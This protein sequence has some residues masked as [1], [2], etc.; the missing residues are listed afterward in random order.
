MSQSYNFKKRRTI[1]NFWRKITFV[2]GNDDCR[3]PLESFMLNER[4][5]YAC[6]AHNF[7]IPVYEIENAVNRMSDEIVAEAEDG[8]AVDLTNYKWK[9]RDKSTN[10][11]YEFK[12]LVHS[13]SKILVSVAEVKSYA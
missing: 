9:Q 8:C 3:E 5:Y 10:R 2:C 4:A 12:V 1:T 6:Q 13:N 11:S 7:H